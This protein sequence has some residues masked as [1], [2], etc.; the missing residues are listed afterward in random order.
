MVELTEGFLEVA[1]GAAFASSRSFAAMK[2][3][4]MNVASTPS[5]PDDG[6]VG[7]LVIAIADDV[8]LSSSQN[9]IR[10]SGALRHLPRQDCRFAGGLRR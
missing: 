9:R 8:G 4:G 6:V 3:V 10:G 2:H 1:I 7:G 5:R